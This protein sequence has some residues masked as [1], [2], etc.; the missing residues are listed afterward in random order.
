M[1]I[2]LCLKLEPPEIF[3]YPIVFDGIVKRIENFFFLFGA[4]VLFLTNFRARIQRIPRCRLTV[5]H[6]L[7]LSEF[8][9]FYQLVIG[10]FHLFYFFA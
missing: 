8:L 7:T 4:H 6:R 9:L 10:Y 2:S 1:A 3:P 5:A